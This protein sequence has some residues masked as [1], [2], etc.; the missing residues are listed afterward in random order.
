MDLNEYACQSLK[1]N[2]PETEVYLFFHIGC[3]YMFFLLLLLLF[4]KMLPDD[5]PYRIL[6]C[7]IKNLFRKIAQKLVFYFLLHLKFK[8]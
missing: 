5:W 3:C 2:H 6:K 4:F 7:C 1:E 8:L